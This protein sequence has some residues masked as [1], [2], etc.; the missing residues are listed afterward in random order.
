MRS[1]CKDQHL[2]DYT[3]S[4]IEKTV[5]MAKATWEELNKYARQKKCCR[6]ATGDLPR[7]MNDS[8]RAFAE[9][10]FESS[11]DRRVFGV[12]DFYWILRYTFLA[13]RQGT[14]EVLDSRR[15][16]PSKLI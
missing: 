9:V 10:G 13:S 3:N 14:L 15:I 8:V 16:E 1:C 2:P 12:A 4:D 11:L 6:N 7:W 5:T